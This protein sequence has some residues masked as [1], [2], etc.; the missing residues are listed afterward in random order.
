MAE[1]AG[2]LNHPHFTSIKHTVHHIDIRVVDGSGAGIGNCHNII[3]PDRF[4]NKPDHFPAGH[5][6]LLCRL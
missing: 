6:S 5:G 4:K 3:D 1:I 2:G